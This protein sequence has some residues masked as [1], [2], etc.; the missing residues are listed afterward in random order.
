MIFLSILAKTYAF[1][2]GPVHLAFSLACWA[3]GL[4]ADVVFFRRRHLSRERR[5]GIV[6]RDVLLMNLG[7][8]LVGCAVQ[9][10]FTYAAMRWKEGLPV[11]SSLAACLLRAIG[12]PAASFRGDLYV[13]TMSGSLSFAVSLD[14]LG[15]WIPAC[16]A[17]FY[18]V[19]LLL[20]AATLRA[21]LRSLGWIIGIMIIV[22]L[23][24]MVVATG[25]F[26]ALCDFVSYETEELPVAPFV[27]PAM[28]AWMFLP[29]LLASWPLLTR[30]L[31]RSAER[32]VAS[33]RSSFCAWALG[34]VFL[35]LLLTAFWEP[36]GRMK[37]GKVLINT[38]HTQWSRT[39]R[40]YDRDWYG[41]DSGYN[42][43]CL[44]RWFEVFYDVRELK[45]RIQA[46]DLEGVSVLIVYLPDRP[47]TEEERRLI[48]EFVRRGGGL[49][50]IGD[51][52]NVFGSTS[53]LN[54]LCAA[55]G[56][57]FRDDVLFD[58]EEDFFQRLDVPRLRSSFLHGMDFFKFR[59]AAS[60]QATSFSTRPV[61]CLDNTKSLRAIY[62]VNNFY[63]PPHDHPS[64]KTGRFC[65]S[66]ASRFGQGRVVAFGDST[67]FSNFEIFYPGKYEYLLNAVHWLNHSDRLL[68]T[69][70]RRCGLLVA[71]LLLAWLLFRVPHPRRWL[72]AC[73]V[74][75]LAFYLARFIGLAAEHV[76]ADFPAP[77]RPTQA[78]FFASEP[79]DPVYV[80]RAFTS[81][82]SYDQ[83]YEV[84]IQW[85][86]RTG[87]FSGFYVTGPGYRNELYAHLCQDPKAKIG[88]ALIVRGPQQ[89]GLLK[90]LMKGPGAKTQR[91]LLAF[92]KQLDW[93]TVAKTL[94]DSGIVS[95]MDALEKVK[96]AWPAGEVILEEGKRRLLLVFSAERFSDQAM[97]FS[98]KVTPNDA[99][100]ALFGQ[101]FSLVDRLFGESTAQT[102]PSAPARP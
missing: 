16:V 90:E 50:V 77:L 80:L 87:A 32:S 69:F 27:K 79:D 23:V 10:A 62:S 11:L 84:F 36:K 33:L 3:A 40:P 85:I 43:A 95:R 1:V 78:L 18:G 102:K 34:P 93:E 21:V 92:S 68:G 56:F 42:Y 31:P 64:M 54:D 49:F 7:V 58:Q 73:V 26:L 37:S 52:T 82:A 66:V 57:V 8:L 99:Q 9:E 25:L 39:D 98:E 13:T 53:H 97:G 14:N 60:I 46:S 35:L 101:E 81:Q 89:L 83:R 67:S 17:S 55:F 5:N 2:L 48:V 45:A 75:L 65:T 74:A 59:G 72:H 19:Y 61:I 71:C 94:Y 4:A 22:A 6:V 86:L 47:F 88:L 30:V 91:L 51:H 20:T 12:L 44:K 100:R 41:A 70:A 28:I 29:F 15:L 63:P 76:R 24:R 38:Y 96:A